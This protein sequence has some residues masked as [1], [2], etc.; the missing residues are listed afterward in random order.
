MAQKSQLK[1]PTTGE[2]IY[3]VTSSSCVGMSDGSG[4]LDNKLTE[5]E[6]K[7]GSQTVEVDTELNEESQKPIA[8]APVA[9]GIN[10]VKQQLSTQKLKRMQ[11]RK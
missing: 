7:I 10:E 8:N 2:K 9:K 5:F 3:P 4:N 1:D 6:E 11:S